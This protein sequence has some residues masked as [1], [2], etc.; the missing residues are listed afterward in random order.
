MSRRVC[1]HAIHGSVG[2][3]TGR[4][5]LHVRVQCNTRQRRA[6][7]VGR[8]IWAKNS[9]IVSVIEWRSNVPKQH[10][11]T[12]CI[13]PL[14]FYEINPQ[15][16]AFHL[17]QRSISLLSLT[18]PIFTPKYVTWRLATSAASITTKPPHPAYK[19]YILLQQNHFNIYK[20]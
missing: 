13:L 3:R 17:R 2:C 4:V 8:P 6:L 12:F 14:N 1:L 18:I 16:G 15:S 7:G 10:P 19:K 9:V 20:M 5:C 11:T